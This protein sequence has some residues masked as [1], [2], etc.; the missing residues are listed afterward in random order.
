MDIT[1]RKIRIPARPFYAVDQHSWDMFKW[2]RTCMGPVFR[3]QRPNAFESLSMMLLTAYGM[4]DTEVKAM[5]KELEPTT[6]Q[7]DMPLYHNLY[8]WTARKPF[9]SH[10]PNGMSLH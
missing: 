9:Q 7:N 4:D 3:P 5:C 10:L 1:Q 8:I 2:Y 6:E